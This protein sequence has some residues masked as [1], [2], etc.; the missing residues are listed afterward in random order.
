MDELKQEN[1]EL[2]RKLAAQ[3]EALSY[4]SRQLDQRSAECQ[5]L[6]RQLEAAL[7]DVREQVRLRNPPLTRN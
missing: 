3:E 6:N 1:L 7:A 4:S 5:A 2:V